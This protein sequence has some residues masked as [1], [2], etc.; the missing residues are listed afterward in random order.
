MIWNAWYGNYKFCWSVNTIRSVSTWRSVHFTSNTPSFSPSTG[1]LLSC[2]WGPWTAECSWGPR[3]LLFQTSSSLERS[4][5]VQGP[6]ARF[7]MTIRGWI[8]ALFDFT[9]RNKMCH[10]TWSSL[11]FIEVVIFCV[12]L[13]LYT[14]RNVK[15]IVVVMLLVALLGTDKQNLP[16]SEGR[17]LQME[18]FSASRARFVAWLPKMATCSPLS[19]QEGRRKTDQYRSKVLYCSEV[20]KWMRE[21][22]CGV[23]LQP[24]WPSSRS[25]PCQGWSQ[26]P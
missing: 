12:L 5:W 6:R 20:D 15:H 26:R 16:C 4:A 22:D 10:V 9:L 25:K 14:R 8:N 11:Q 17:R 24:P 13:Y 7:L 19:S 21:S 1:V 18:P 23:L 2:I 3:L